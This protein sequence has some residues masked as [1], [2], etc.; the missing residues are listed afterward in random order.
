MTTKPQKYII[1]CNAATPTFFYGEIA[2]RRGSEADLVNVRRIRRWRGAR[3]ISQVATE[4]ISDESLVSMPVAAMTVL[5]ICE[6]VPVT[7]SAAANIEAKPE[8]KL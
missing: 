1:V 3:T 2:E 7:D 8:W 6:I 4:G 5:N